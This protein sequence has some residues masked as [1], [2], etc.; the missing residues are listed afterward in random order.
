MQDGRSKN[1]SSGVHSRPSL[2]QMPSS[3]EG[4]LKKTTH[5]SKGSFKSKLQLLFLSRLRSVRRLALVNIR[6]KSLGHLMI[7]TQGRTVQVLLFIA[8]R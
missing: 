7:F 3:T 5:N 2:P 6:R 8:L 1:T 4:S